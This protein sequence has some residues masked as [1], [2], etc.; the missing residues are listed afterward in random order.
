MWTEANK[1]VTLNA[2]KDP[3]E[4][5]LPRPSGSFSSEHSASRF[6]PN[7]RGAKK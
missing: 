6:S 4:R 3:E 5:Y 1:V 7:K 2:V